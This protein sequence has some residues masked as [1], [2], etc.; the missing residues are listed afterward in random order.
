MP[1]SLLFI[2][3]SK[4]GEIC[5]IVLPLQRE[6]DFRGS[7]HLN[8]YEQSIENHHKINARKRHAKSMEND[9]KMEAKWR[10]KSHENLKI[11]EKMHAKNRC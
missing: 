3:F 10:P 4:K 7:G 1:T 8:M 9:A 2:R 6:H 11:C 5:E